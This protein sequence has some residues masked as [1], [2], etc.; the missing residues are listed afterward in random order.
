MADV[1]PFRGVR[2]DASH[3]D[4][5]LTIAP[6]YDVISADEQRALYVRSE[7]NIVRVEYG[8]QRD[9]DTS[10]DNRYTRAAADL[11][12][13]RQTGILLRDEAPAVYAYR[14]EFSW[15]GRIYLRRHYFAAVRL[16]PWD[17]GVIKP[18]ERTLSGPKAD[19]LDLLRATRTQVS[20]VYCLYRA[21]AAAAALA[22]LEGTPLYDFEADGQRHILAAVIEPRAQAVFSDHL[23]RCDVYIADGHHRYET[24]LKYR[25]E[26]RGQAGSWTGEEPENFVLMALTPADDPG[27]LVLPTHR[28]LTSAAVRADVMTKIARCFRVEDVGALGDAS[29]LEAALRRLD[30]AKGE[31]AFV[32][33][34]LEAGRVTLLT[35]IDRAAIESLMPEDQP[36]AWRR[37]DV[38]VLQYGILGRVFDID[39]AAIMAGGAVSYT[40]DASLACDAVVQGRANVAFLLNATPVDQVLAVADAGGRMP[41]KSTY[42]YPKLPTGLV[43]N[44]LDAD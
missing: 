10:S 29:I 30:A 42:F 11:A 24:A 39:D 12:A 38:S 9:G 4:P 16:E 27:L 3:A 21:R 41:Q 34:G 14:Q 13:W 28:L 15:E 33:A 5:T 23:A 37:L 17:A 22:D 25:D 6:P 32:A 18:H 20:P 36:Q 2:F 7:H 31:A 26:C 19:R 40:Q 8:A 43:M 35:L 1:R 44:A